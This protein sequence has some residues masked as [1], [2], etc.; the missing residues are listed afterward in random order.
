L[1]VIIVSPAKAEEVAIV[2]PYIARVHFVQRIE[3]RHSVVYDMPIKQLQEDR[4]KYLESH[5]HS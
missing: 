4:E 2:E 3:N 1:Q 5:D